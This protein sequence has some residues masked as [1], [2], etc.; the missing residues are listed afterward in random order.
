MT[1]EEFEKEREELLERVKK[2]EQIAS[3]SQAEAA[4]YRD[5][6]EDLYK[7]ADQA[8]ENNDLRL[9]HKITGRLAFWNVPR[10]GD[11]KEWGKYFLH[12]YIRDASWLDDTKKALEKIKGYA[13]RLAVETDPK[14]AEL[15]ESILKTA[16]D[17]LIPHI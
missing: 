4:V 2:A 17:G 5:L 16:E 9:L 7:A 11:V 3:E 6:L 10:E 14:N 13:E 1:T 8:L 15:R 12:A